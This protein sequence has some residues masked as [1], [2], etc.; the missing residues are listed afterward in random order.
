MAGYNLAETGRPEQQANL[1]ACVRKGFAIRISKRKITASAILVA[2]DQ[3]LNNK[4]AKQEV[5]KFQTQ[6]E[7]WDAPKNAAK[8]LYETFGR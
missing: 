4:K 3:L 7:N 2:I 6:L 5:V 1:D 8:F